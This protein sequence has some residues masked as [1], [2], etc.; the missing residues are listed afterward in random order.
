VSGNTLRREYENC[1]PANYNVAD[2][3]SEDV[4]I[5][6]LIDSTHIEMLE[7]SVKD[8]RIVYHRLP[9]LGR[10]PHIK[11]GNNLFC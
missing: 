6:V 4:G 7:I 2:D 10:H 3:I 1:N 8:I 11:Q 9:S 5:Q